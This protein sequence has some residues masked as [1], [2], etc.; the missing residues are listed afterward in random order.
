[1]KIQPTRLCVLVC[2]IWGSAHISA[3][4]Q[5]TEATETK[6]LDTVVVS[7]A[8]YEQDIKDAP[9][10]ISIVSGEQLRNRPMRNLEDA[11]RNLEGVSIVANHGNSEEI[12]IRGMPGEYTLIL[13]DGKRQGTRETMNRGT[14]GVQ[15][16]FIPPA[17]AIERIEVIRGPM[18]ALYGSD[19]IG[20]VINI[21]TRKVPETWT[22]SV[23]VGGILQEDSLYGNTTQ[24][25]FWLSGPI[26]H[27]LLSLQLYGNLQNR[28]EDNIYY[29]NGATG[30]NGKRD[31][32]I[33][34]KLIITPNKDHDIVLE[35]G[36]DTLTYDATPGRTASPTAAASTVRKTEHDHETLS[37]SHTGRWSFG[38]TSLS[39]YREV[40]TKDETLNSGSAAAANP[41]ITNT[42]I[43]AL[44]TLPF[45]SNILKVGAQYNKA[46]A[47]G[48][49]KQDAIPGYLG[50][51]NVDNVSIN[52][53]A[54][55]VEDEYFFT[56]KFKMTGGVRYD[57]HDT[58]GTHYTPRLYANYDINDAWSVHGGIAKGFKAPTIRQSTAGYCMTSG[59]GVMNIGTLCG[60][61]NLKPE[62]STTQ[63][64]GIR[65][66]PQPGMY[67]SATVF[68]N[69]FKNKVASYDTGVPDPLV[70]GR[71]IYIYDNIDKV[72]IR[73]VEL[74]AAYPINPAWTVS[75]NYTYT[76]SKRQGDGGEPSYDGTSLD[77]KPL[78]KTPEHS[79]SLTVDWKPSEQLSA[80]VTGKYTGAMYW[81]AYRNGANA[82]R[83]RGAS[84]TFDLGASYAITKNFSIKAAVLNLNNKLVPVD[85]RTRTQGL[86]GNWMVDEGRRLWVS[87]TYTF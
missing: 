73:G 27:D 65:F 48:I 54:L 62:E 10:S 13:V 83:K 26:K 18:S 84:T 30:S 81:S 79:A 58:F 12:S 3:V 16:N 49:G 34:A 59:G 2:A 23:T 20:G 37:I 55:F 70:S 32:G 41:K 24:S 42:L 64:V 69:D 31:K 52:S 76:K 44:V 77:G 87:G 82:T 4:A 21:I 68:N 45:T 51:V 5:T 29:S 75:G 9:A 63:E 7:A 61:P 17:A 11:V 71:N 66:A 33:H 53:W 40:G 46:E 74:A 57:H 50:P 72:N 43:D 39:A 19:A 78:D 6:Q 36:R 15:T 80:Y 56:D 22:G 60:N 8:G 35:A 85:S 28:S 25:N 38:T 1:M 47:D 67:V 14:G 86:D